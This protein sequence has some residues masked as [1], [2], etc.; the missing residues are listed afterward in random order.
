MSSLDFSGVT[1]QKEA[2]QDMIFTCAECISWLSDNMTL[3][4]GQVRLTI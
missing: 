4:P 2:T 1:Q 3:M